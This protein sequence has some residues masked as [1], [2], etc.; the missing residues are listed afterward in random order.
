MPSVKKRHAIIS[1]RCVKP[2]RKGRLIIVTDN[3]I[4]ARLICRTMARVLEE[5]AKLVGLP[6]GEVRDLKRIESFGHSS[7][8]LYEGKPSLSIGHYTPK[9]FEGGTSY[10][11]RLWRTGAG[12]HASMRKRFII[13]LQTSGGNRSYGSK[14]VNKS[15]AATQPGGYKQSPKPNGEEK[16]PNKKRT[17]EKQRKRNERRLLKKQQLEQKEKERS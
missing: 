13:A 11:D 8:H 2:N 1:A 15:Y 16:K 10:F 9:Q 17:S 6:L 3:L 14:G 4:Y 12:K 5:D 7:I